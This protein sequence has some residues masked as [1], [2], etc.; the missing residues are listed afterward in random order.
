ME[1]CTYDHQQFRF[2]SIA[3]EILSTESLELLHT[4]LDRDLAMLDNP[5]N[6]QN[7][8]FHQHFYNAFE[9]EQPA[10]LDTYTRF[11]RHVC[12]THCPGREMVFQTRPTF[13]VHVP[14]NIAV[15]EFHKDRNY[16][17]SPYERNIYVPLTR[18]F[19]T[20]TI[21]VESSEDQAD[22]AP[23]ELVYGE[24]Y[25]WDGANLTHGNRVNDTGITRVSFDFRII[26]H[27]RFQYEGASVTS[28]VPMKIGYYWSKA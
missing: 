1:K 8:V 28:H 13:R 17:H 22:Y 19:G 21:W 9:E 3:R 11:A 27:D 23:M 12:E 24:Y 25:L 2:A 5:D 15:A 20:N 14:N 4:T 18:A 26:E 16:N 7:T 10:F 6:D